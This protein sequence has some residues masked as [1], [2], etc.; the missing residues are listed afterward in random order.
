M[1]DIS[2]SGD[3]KHEKKNLFQVILYFYIYLFINLLPCWL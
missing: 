2:T 1:S 3:V